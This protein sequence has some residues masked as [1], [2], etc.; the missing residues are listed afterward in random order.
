M[1]ELVKEILMELRRNATIV[2]VR[3]EELGEVLKRRMFQSIDQEG[4]TRAKREL[5]K[6]RD[7]SPYVEDVSEQVLQSYPFH[8]YF[9]GGSEERCNQL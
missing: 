4:A 6:L 3:V 7:F 8:P 2:P 1:R 9:P 5:S